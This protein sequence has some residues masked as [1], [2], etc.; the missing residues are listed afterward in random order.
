[1][2]G[3]GRRAFSCERSSASTVV[4]RDTVSSQLREHHKERLI[5]GRLPAFDH[6]VPDGDVAL[7][8]PALVVQD[9]II[10]LTNHGRFPYPLLRPPNGEWCA[11][12]VRQPKQVREWRGRSAK[13]SLS[14][15]APCEEQ[16]QK[17]PLG[18]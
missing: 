6:F 7:E 8:L 9:L 18:A 15:Q 10:I 4:I 13:L 1:M 12:V 14:A 16:A 3:A 17:H 5:D 11:A 2:G